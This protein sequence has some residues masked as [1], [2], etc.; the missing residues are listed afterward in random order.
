MT[1]YRGEGGG[2]NATTDSELNKLTELTQQSQNFA[3]LAE[4]QATNAAASAVNA[5]T[6]EAN[7]LSSENSAAL[8]ATL[9]Q[10]WAIKTDAP[11][12]GGEYSSKYHAQ[13]A[14]SSA[15]SASI[16]A[17]NA[18]SSETNAAAYA[19]SINPSDLVHIS[20]TET[21][22]G[23]K[24][25][26]NTIV[27]S[28]SG[29]ATTVTNGVYTS[30]D[31]TIAGTKTFSS[32]ISGS[33]TTQVSLTGNENIA[34]TKT[35]SSAPVIPGINGGQLAGMRNKIINGKMDVAQR[36]AAF[37]SG[38]NTYTLDRWL[39][40]YFADGGAT[41]VQSTDIPSSNEFQN[42][43]RL[44]V[45]TAD[46]SIA[47]AQYARFEQKIEGYNARDLIGKTFTLSFWV[48]SS[49]TGIHCVALRNSGPDRSYIAEYTINAANTWEWKNITV[50]GG[51]PT[52]GTWNWT[53][54]AGLQTSFAIA[55]G[56]TFQTTAGAWQT[57]NFLTTANQVN[58]LDTVGNIFAI[59]G[60]Q[61]EVGSVATPFEHR[62]Y[63][64]ELA[65]C[66]R[67]YEV[68]TGQL[69]GGAYNTVDIMFSGKFQISKRATPT[70]ASLVNGS[71]VG[72]NTTGTITTMSFSAAT[73][74][75]YLCDATAFTGTVTQ[76]YAYVLRSFTHSASAEL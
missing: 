42:S 27:G 67:Y 6:S 68:I 19:A 18:A 49:K 45:N 32:P 53:N 9:A 56:S 21:V 16:S 34:G 3:T 30:G 12:S 36:G 40:D 20:G 71:W 51:L 55:C 59:T 10:D 29:N 48:R 70:M 1:I 2:G 43:L 33:T 46:T 63:G 17:S 13:N 47:A 4:I 58:C 31:Q 52:A 8:S 28:I 24:T 15:S 38:T 11:V 44:T 74:D 60:V 54:G 14:S 66:Q 7:A 23:T 69:S 25:F 37:V 65:L 62:P 39:V 26:S 61:L 57:G 41:T 75:A 35:F 22:T 76:G 72:S 64:A 73:T 5:A 50:A